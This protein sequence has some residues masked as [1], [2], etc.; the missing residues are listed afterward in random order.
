MRQIATKKAYIFNSLFI[1]HN[2]GIMKNYLYTL[3]VRH[4]LLLKANWE[5][6]MQNK[7]ICFLVKF[8]PWN[9]VYSVGWTPC[10]PLGSQILAASRLES[11]VLFASKVSVQWLFF[12]FPLVS[13]PNMLSESR[14]YCT[15]CIFFLNFPYFPN[16]SLIFLKIVLTYP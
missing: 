4:I 16:I 2:C 7:S 5:V 1:T 15:Y 6:Q 13:S 10:P 11:P 9:W 14:A 3:I 12:K 8:I